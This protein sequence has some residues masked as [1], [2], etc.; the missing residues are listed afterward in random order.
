M[1]LHS[2]QWRG[3]RG[4]RRLPAGPKADKVAKD[5]KRGV[6]KAGDD[7]DKLGRDVKKGTVKSGDDLKKAFAKAGALSLSRGAQPHWGRECRH[8]MSQSV[9]RQGACRSP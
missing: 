2:G 6:H 1:A 3:L 4:S 5:V 7:L 9:G 8:P